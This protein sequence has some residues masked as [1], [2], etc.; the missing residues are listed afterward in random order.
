MS[1]GF[2][3]LLQSM[4]STIGKIMASPA[5]KFILIGFLLII[6]IIPLFFV[7]TI[8]NDRKNSASNAKYDISGKWGKG[9]TLRGPY[10]VVPTIKKTEVKVNTYE[11]KEKKE[12][13]KIQITK[14][15]AVFLPEELSIKSNVKTE[16]RKRGIFS[17]PVY[18]SFTDISGRFIKPDTTK[19][20]REVDELI[21]DDAV[22]LFMVS[23]INAIK[24]NII[25]QINSGET[26]T[27]FKAGTGHTTRR[28]IYGFHAPLTAGHAS[29]QFDFSLTLNINGSSNLHFV[30]IGRNTSGQVKSDWPHPSF[31]GQFL[32][33]TRQISDNGFDAK[34]NIPLLATGQSKSFL[35]NQVHQFMGGTT[36]GVELFQTS[37][38]YKLIDKSLKYAMGFIAVAFFAV[39]ILEIQSGVRVHWIQYI[40]VGLASIIFYLVLLGLSE[41][42]GFELAY[43]LSFIATSILIATY[44]GRAMKS[45]ARGL[46]ILLVLIFIYGLLYL[47]L[48]MED[49]AMLIGSISAFT[50][51]A[52]IMFSTGNVDWT[53]LKAGKKR[54]AEEIV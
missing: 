30:P 23:D 1:N 26:K 42:T 3:D 32:P 35:T 22:M 28:G 20:M 31:Q 4:F 36:F 6:L 8:N 37:G 12:T 44:V 10:L 14:R 49:Y 13:T 48:R 39:F 29:N 9:Q 24:K 41:H 43:G 7:S 16:T 11:G 50:L 53:G 19:I 2:V 17:V 34:W 52:I 51:L 21:W 18:K 46:S 45:V 33:D 5:A 47:L 38:Y 54:E 40:F 15:L 25:L 27:P